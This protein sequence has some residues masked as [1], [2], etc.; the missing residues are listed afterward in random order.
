MARYDEVIERIRSGPYWRLVIRPEPFAENR[1]RLEELLPTVSKATVRFRGWDFPHVNRNKALFTAANY[2]ATTEDFLSHLEHWRMYMSGQFVYIAGVRES[3]DPRWKEKL[4]RSARFSLI[5]PSTDF[6]WSKVPGFIEVV[7]FVYTITEFFELAARLNQSLP[8]TEAT[9]IIIGLH[10]IEGFVLTVDDFNRGGLWDPYAA[11]EQTLENAW[12]IP[13]STLV[14]ASENLTLEA[15]Q[16]F[17]VRFGWMEPN[18]EQIKRDI[19]AL[20]QRGP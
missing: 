1:L 5:A 15:I 3:T 16:W 9:K 8:D 7:N 14:R 12:T 11:D 4:A 17:L 2:I 10:N 13:L 19:R 20:T 18:T 6:D